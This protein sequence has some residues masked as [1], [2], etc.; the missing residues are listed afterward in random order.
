MVDKAGDFPTRRPISIEINTEELG[1]TT[2]ELVKPTNFA[3]LFEEK[4]Q[5]EFVKQKPS[6][7]RTQLSPRKAKGGDENAMRRSNE[8]Q[9]HDLMDKHVRQR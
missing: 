9:L 8:K 4:F 7:G 1:R 3:H 5:R 6:W 2:N